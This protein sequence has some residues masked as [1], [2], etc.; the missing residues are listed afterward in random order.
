MEQPSHFLPQNHFPPKSF[1]P[2]LS[3][4]SLNLTVKSTTRARHRHRH[5]HLHLRRF[6]PFS[7]PKHFPSTPSSTTNEHKPSTGTSSPPTRL[8][9]VRPAPSPDLRPKSPFRFSQ[10][11]NLSLPLSISGC[12]LS[13]WILVF[14]VD[15][16]F[17]CI[18][19]LVFLGV[20]LLFL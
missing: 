8:P 10:V 19:L 2:S 18:D 14:G 7:S 9:L 6:N 4:S 12:S 16:L 17:L 15:S 3:I 1:P 5:V 11:P 13:L 20:D